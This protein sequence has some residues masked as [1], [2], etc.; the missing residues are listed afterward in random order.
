MPRSVVCRTRLS[1]S[2]G[3]T[4]GHGEMI[5]DHERIMWRNTV[6]K[7]KSHF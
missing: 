2:N 5:L 4:Q 6:L 3:K 1:N 7:L